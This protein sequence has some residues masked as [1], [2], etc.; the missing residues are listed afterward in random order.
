MAAIDDGEGGEIIP[1]PGMRPNPKLQE[2]WER[3]VARSNEKRKT[4]YEFQGPLDVLD[5][6]MAKRNLP[7]M[8]WP[9]AWPRIA[10]RARTYAGD[11][12]SIAGAKGGGKTSFAV[13]ACLANTGDG[14]PVLW[15]PLDLDSSQIITRIVASMHGVHT[16]EIRERWP[17]EKI[18]HSLRAVHDMWHFVPRYRE[19]TEQI[20][21][22]LEGIDIAK[23]TYR[24]PP[25][26]VI[27]YLGKLAQQARDIRLATIAAVAEMQMA[28]VR[29]ECIVMILC[30]TSRANERMLTGRDDVDSA[31]DT[32][33]VAADASAVEADARTQIALSVFKADDAPSLDAHVHV[34]K[35]NVGLEGRVGFRFHKSGGVWEELGYIPTTPSQVKAEV[36]KAKRDKHRAGPPP[37]PEQSRQDLN[38][39]ASSNAELVHRGNLLAAIRRAGPEGLMPAQ[40][41]GL[42]GAGRGI[43]V[44]ASLQELERHGSIERTADGAWR[45]VTRL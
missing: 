13:Q 15:A 36:E 20:H 18:A 29:E 7:V 11:V 44:T 42:R 40:I 41:R 1:F 6:L 10:E 16:G 9:A 32:M 8:R 12:I 27:D 37:T 25:I 3:E 33:G 26:V 21:A 5:Q 31:T 39:T 34:S 17:R 30:Q 19:S 24:V 14:I 45:A 23:R 2:A 22:L 38:A 4:G 35:S 43:A 28:A